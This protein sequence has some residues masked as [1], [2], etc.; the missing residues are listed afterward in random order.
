MGAP[1]CS[2][3]GVASVAEGPGVGDGIDAVEKDTC[4]PP[5]LGA[6]VSRATLVGC[7]EGASRDDEG[8]R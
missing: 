5:A 8:R 1:H 3:A 7:I 2:D 4:Q 6:G